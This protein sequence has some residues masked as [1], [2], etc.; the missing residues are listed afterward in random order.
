M[1]MG[2][3]VGNLS[4][5]RDQIFREL[6]LLEKILFVALLILV[7]AML[8][9]GDGRVAVVV[10]FYVVVRL[11]LKFAATGGAV[12][13]HFP[14]FRTLG[15]RSGFAFTAQGGMATAIALDCTMAYQFSLGNLILATVATAVVANDILSLVL[16][17]RSLVRSGEAAKSAQKKISRVAT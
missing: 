2:F 16:V 17:K 11:M 5:K 9:V 12:K 1:I 8:D 7:G 6:H 15:R 14:E 13:A 10:V 3:V 4:R